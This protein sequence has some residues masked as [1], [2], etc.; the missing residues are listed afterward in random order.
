[1]GGARRRTGR[2]TQ[3]ASVSARRRSTL[4]ASR[5]RSLLAERF[6]APLREAL[7]EETLLGLL[8][9]ACENARFPMP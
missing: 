3:S 5:L 2:W 7:D 1:M 8:G 4:R 9:I 6:M